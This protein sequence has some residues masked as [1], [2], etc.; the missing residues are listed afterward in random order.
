[1]KHLESGIVWGAVLLVAGILLVLGSLG[2]QIAE[3]A[4]RAILLLVGGAP[5]SP[6]AAGAGRARARPSLS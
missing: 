3:N 4:F 5:V 1:M 6:R 2:V